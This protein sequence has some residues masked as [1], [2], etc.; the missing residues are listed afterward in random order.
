MS[1][2]GSNQK[3]FVATMAEGEEF[4]VEGFALLCKRDDL[5][6]FYDALEAAGLL[7]PSRNSGPVAAAE[8][9]Y[10]RIPYWS[11]LDYLL[12][13]AKKAG[14]TNDMALSEK[15]NR[16]I[17]GVA[18]WRDADGQKRENPNTYWRFAEIWAALPREAITMDD[19]A[20][21]PQ[22]LGVPFDQG[23]AGRVLVKDVI[24]RFLAGNSADDIEKACRLLRDCTAFKW[25][26]GKRY[27]KEVT[28]L[29]DSHWLQQLTSRQ[30]AEFGA[31]AGA[32]AS[33]IFYERLGELFGHQKRQSSSTL[34]RAAI[35]DHKQNHA[36][37][38]IENQLIDGLRDVLLAWIDTGS[39]DAI[40]AVSDYLSDEK[41]IVRRIALHVIDE[42]FERVGTVFW[43][44][45]SPAVFQIGHIH[46]LYRLLGR[47]FQG[48]SPAEHDRILDVIRHLPPPK[49]EDAEGRL[50]RMQRLWLSAIM[51]KGSV[52]ADA[53]FGQ[54]NADPAMGGLS[55]HPDF[56]SYHETFS[57]PGPSPL[58]EES[59]FALAEEGSLV[60]RLNAF[61][62]TNAWR[63]PTMGGLCSVLEQA[64]FEKTELFMKLFTEFQSANRPYQYSLL[65]GIKRRW[66]EGVKAPDKFDWA[67]A[68]PRIL[69][70]GDAV[71]K[72]E[73]F[74]EE[75]GEEHIDLTPRREWIG[76][77]IAD[78]IQAGARNDTRGYGPTDFGA[79][80]GILAVLLDKSE[81]FAEI[82]K[83]DDAMNLAINTAKGRTIEALLNH[84]LKECR[85]QDKAGGGHAAAWANVQPFFD[86]ELE[87]CRNA[88]FDF[89]ALAAN[90]LGNIGY[91]SEAWQAG[92]I[93]RIFPAEY[94]VNMLSALDGLAYAVATQPIFRLLR[95]NGV[96]TWA[97]EHELGE[98]AREKLVE[99][100]VLAYIWGEEPLNSPL[101]GALFKNGRYDD[102][103]T[104]GQW[105]WGI[106]GERLEDDQVERV[107]A[108]W[109][110]AIATLDAD[111]ETR[112]ELR[113]NLSRLA[114][115]IRAIGEREKALLLAVAPYVQSNYNANEFVGELIRLADLDSDTVSKVLGAML[116]GSLPTFDLDDKLKNLLK[117]LAA[118]GNK[119]DVIA[120]AEALQK[121]LPGMVAFYM[122]LVSGA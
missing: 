83:S 51:G 6:R 52:A 97:L 20:L 113:S 96:L 38:E 75:Q 67:A 27:S 114:I 104:A 47:R 16:V 94:P 58:A 95:D 28:P 7:D 84:A 18:A 49:G 29:V 55:D 108:F 121:Q 81:G 73:G 9:G 98:N 61:T 101:V 77:M 80:R 5:E 72:S 12:A 111:G 8:P 39:A 54:L 88:N 70:F 99:R 22:W 44:K 86:T 42:K 106:S 13:L 46:E 78:L 103:N 76:P 102:L 3:S 82:G 71:I 43:Q 112:A 37:H 30:A 109:E 17:R 100:I 40:T 21:V 118:S 24:P 32:R 74:W 107:L 68:W 10:F 19:L 65:A 33:G 53:W 26:E 117:K 66:E 11:A 116:T 50:R 60:E 35:E 79:V 15:V 110:R 2:L 48:F 119:L 57:G 56:L 31:K 115:Y 90:Y 25:N 63:A 122:E 69:A 89:S 93:K 85:L 23:M 36:F 34:W 59:L 45:L 14:S 91:M 120:Y 41:E 87:K 105:L 64:V 4:A 62:E 1:D 92:R